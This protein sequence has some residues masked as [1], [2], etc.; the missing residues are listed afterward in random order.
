[1][2]KKIPSKIMKKL[3]KHT[4]KLLDKMTL[5]LFLGKKLRKISRE[6]YPGFPKERPEIFV[7][8]CSHP[9]V[10]YTLR[11]SGYLYCTKCGEKAK[12]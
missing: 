3:I 4:N 7:A 2:I 11:S 5:D 8:R 1:M 9:T 6:I 10:F 12:I